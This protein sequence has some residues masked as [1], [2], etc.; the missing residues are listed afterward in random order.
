MRDYSKV[1]QQDV[2]A[3]D[4]KRAKATFWA[5]MHEV[6]GRIPFARQAVAL[7]FLIREPGVDLGVKASAVLALLYFISPIDM[8]PD[9][10]PVTGLLDD[11]AVISAAIVVLGSMIKPFLER[12]DAWYDRGRP[13]RDEPEIEEI[14]DV[15]PD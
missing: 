15:E 5:K 12:A 11:A 9:V 13:L 10:I 3:E 2:S 7:Y 8:I 6:I 14:R 1:F 4:L